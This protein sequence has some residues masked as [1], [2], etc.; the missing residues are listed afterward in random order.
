M[1]KNVKFAEFYYYDED[2]SDDDNKIYNDI[3]NTFFRE[4]WE[5][6]DQGKHGLS[7]DEFFKV[8]NSFYNDF[9]SEA[10]SEDLIYEFLKEKM[11]V[12]N[13]VIDRDL[14]KGYEIKLINLKV[15]ECEENGVRMNIIM[16]FMMT[17]SAHSCYSW[18]ENYNDGDCEFKLENPNKVNLDKPTINWIEDKILNL[19][20]GGVLNLNDVLDVLQKARG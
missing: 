17:Y 18:V 13:K 10:E 16:Q 6:S 19:S 4:L 14:E 7:G 5:I 11:F 15:G 1:I 20:Q 12:S 3:I 8:Y 2:L 9:D